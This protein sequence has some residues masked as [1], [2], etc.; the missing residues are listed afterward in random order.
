MLPETAFS[1]ST[2]RAIQPAIEKRAFDVVAPCREG[3]QFRLDEVI[4]V[5]AAPCYRDNRRDTIVAMRMGRDLSVRRDPK[6]DGADPDLV[7]IAFQDHCLNTNDSRAS[8]AWIAS[9]RELIVCRRQALFR[10]C[11]KKS[12]DQSYCL[13][14][15]FLHHPAFGFV[16]PRSLH[17]LYLSIA[18]G[19]GGQVQ[20]K[21]CAVPRG[22]DR[23][24]AS[25]MRLND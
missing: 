19:R 5:A 17:R 7:R 22:A 6:H 4:S 12:T 9:Y 14:R 2:N 1:P 11:V 23:P 20:V 18:W 13:D 15:P 10:R 16:I 3:L 24:Q 25:T 8:R 21:S